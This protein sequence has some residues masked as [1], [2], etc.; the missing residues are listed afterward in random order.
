MSGIVE[1]GTPSKGM[2]EIIPE[3]KKGIMEQKFH[4]GHMHILLKRLNQ[5]QGF[6]R[7]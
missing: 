2:G 7:I 3:E 5:E 6:C 1:S 4:G